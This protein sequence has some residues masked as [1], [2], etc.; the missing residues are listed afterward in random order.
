VNRCHWPSTLAGRHGVP[1][2]ETD[3]KGR[4][5]SDIIGQERVVERIVIALLAN[6]NVLLEGLPGLANTR[7]VKS[8]SKNLDAEFRRIQFTP[9][10][11]PSDVTGGEIL[12]GDGRFESRKGPIFGSLVLTDKINRAPAMVQSALLEAMEQRHVTVAAT[13]Y[14]LPPL[15]MVLATQNPIEQEGTYPLPEAQM[16]RFLIH[17]RIDYPSDA[18]ELK[19]L[20]LLRDENASRTPEK[21]EP[22]ERIRK[23]VIFRARAEIEAVTTKSIVETYI[24]SLVAA[25]RRPSQ[26]GDKLK[27]WIAIGASPRGSIGLYRCSRVHA[28]LQGRDYV[29]PE[30]VPAVAHVVLRHRISLSYEATVERLTADDV[31]DEIVKQVAVAA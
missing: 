25:S 4:I 31:V 11:L 21:A 9:D 18:S 26:F 10:L 19:V 20:Q 29:T 1:L 17:V 7:A 14:D 22:S 24:V 16:D 23:D 5:N 27:G 13:R 8:L 3:L 2:F 30:D 12:R 15:F 28:W 6:G